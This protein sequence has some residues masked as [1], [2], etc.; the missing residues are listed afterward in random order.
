MGQEFRSSLAGCFWLMVFPEVAV[1]M[2]VKL[3]SSEGLTE[4][5]G[6]TSKMVHSLGV[7]R[8]QFF[9]MCTSP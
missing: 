8:P 1:K 5:G 7:G 6:S 2:L 3:E 4:A 9:E